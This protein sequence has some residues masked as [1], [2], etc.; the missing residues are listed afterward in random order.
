MPEEV[1]Y[2]SDTGLIRVRVWGDDPIEDWVQSREKVLKTYE[3]RGAFMVIADV[4]EQTTAPSIMDIIEFGENW[5]AEIR[6]AILMSEKTRDDVTVLET[7][8]QHQAKSM[9]VFFDEDEAIQ[10]LKQ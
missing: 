10:W 5:P 1:S 8:G 3:T 7:V 4:R 9:R 6:L 2:E